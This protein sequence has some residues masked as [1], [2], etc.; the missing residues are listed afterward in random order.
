VFKDTPLREAL[1]S[2]SRW[3]EADL[4]LDDDAVWAIGNMPL[5]AVLDR[6]PLDQVVQLLIGTF[7]VKADRRTTADTL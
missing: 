5:T 3:Y 1:V 2:L 7:D 4:L 6:E